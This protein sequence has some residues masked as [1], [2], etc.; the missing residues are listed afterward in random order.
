LKDRID[1]KFVRRF[2]EL[3]PMQAASD[4]SDDLAPM[5]CGGCGSKVGSEILDQ[6]L[7][8][9]GSRYAATRGSG[10]EH[11]DDAALIR[12]PAGLEL[13]QSVDHF[14]SFIDDPYLFGRIA[15][16]HALGDL[17]AMG[18]D[19]HSALV[20][21]NVVFASEARQAQDLYQLMSGVAETLAQHNTLLVGGHSGEA[22]QMSCGLSVNGFARPEELL[23]KSGMR[24]GDMLILTRALGSGVLFAAEMRGARPGA[25]RLDRCGARA[26]AGFE[27]CGGCL[28]AE[29]RRQRLHRRHRLRAG[30]SLVRNGAR[31]RLRGGDSA[32]AA[33]A[34]SRGR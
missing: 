10:F 9:I 11:A 14:R 29:L 17:F 1:R 13:V 30:R 33:A 26:D 8:E 28:P 23:L 24:P 12:V 31:F 2:T 5:R 7:A 25:R 4:E 22:S 20:I 18:V 34:L 32:P 15:A 6:V 19:P 21:A 3:P 16:N 27:S